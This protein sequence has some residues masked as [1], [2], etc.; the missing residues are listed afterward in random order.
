MGLA[1]AGVRGRNSNVMPERCGTEVDD[2]CAA[3]LLPKF[4]KT[5]EFGMPGSYLLHD[6]EPRRAAMEAAAFPKVADRTDAFV[7]LFAK[8]ER[9]V[10]HDN[11]MQVFTD[12]NYLSDGQP[13]PSRKKMRPEMITRLLTRKLVV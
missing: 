3:I 7:R 13:D 11:A 5:K 1:V 9:I 2:E 6:Y 8:M 12:G 10:G 4:A